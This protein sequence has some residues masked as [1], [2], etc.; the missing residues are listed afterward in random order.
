MTES[1]EPEY[2]CPTCFTIAPWTDGTVKAKG[3]ERDEFWCQTC[4]F[5]TP[6][7]ECRQVKAAGA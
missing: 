2:E 6:L 1:A 5:E 3:D 7:E 4:G